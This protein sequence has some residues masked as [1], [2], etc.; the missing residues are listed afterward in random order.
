[1]QFKISKWQR[2]TL[3]KL[4]DQY[5]K[6]KTY[7]G[8]NQVTQAFTIVPEKIFSNYASDYVNV[9][10]VRDFECQM[11]E[12]EQKGIISIQWENHVIQHLA[13]NPQ[14][15]EET[16]EVLGRK[17]LR[18]LEGEQIALYKGYL[19]Y[20][21]ILDCFCREQIKRLEEGKKA[22]YALGEADKILK[23][24]IFI[25]ENQEEI[26]ERELSIA[27][28]GDSKLWKEKYRSKVCRLLKNY[29]DFDDLLMGI[30]D[31]ET[32]KIILGEYHVVSNPSY[33]YFKGNAELLFKDREMLRINLDRP[34]AF[35][36]KTIENIESIKI[37]N[38]KVVTVENLASFNRLGREDSFYIF[39]SGYHNQLKQKLLCRIYKENKRIEWHH[40]GDIDPD[41]FYIM[42]HL[43]NGTGIPFEPMNM[44]VSHL[45]KYDA[46]AKPLEENDIR[47]AKSLLNEHK[48]SQ[49][50]EYMLKEGKKLEQEIISWME[51]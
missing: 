14:K 43:K 1:M 4:V 29:G 27:V 11:K 18:Y 7:R 32:E 3:E 37:W 13:A 40:F 48:Y 46:Y 6:S 26:L 51:K 47:K 17:E 10:D 24:C 23:L 15:W 30:D 9:D 35:T 20:N 5:E 41:G 25:L 39:L 44:D 28:L 49:I 16:Y 36:E 34:V 50:M 2:E 42:E 8:E 33:I 21:E 19:D 38:K 31:K 22:K 45:K 12:L